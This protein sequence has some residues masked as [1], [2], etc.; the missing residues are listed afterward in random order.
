VSK[1]R[2]A[3]SL[4]AAV[5]IVLVGAGV[6]SS[7]LC[8][9]WELLPSTPESH[10]VIVA[11]RTYLPVSTE[12]GGYTLEPHSFPSYPFRVLALPPDGA[13]IEVAV[14]PERGDRWVGSFVPAT[15]GSWTL[16]ITNLRGSEARCYRDGLLRVGD[17]RQRNLWIGIVAAVAVAT[18]AGLLL[19]RRSRRRPAGSS[20][21][22]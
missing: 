17:T 11:F 16:R 12:D 22:T 13:A 21:A 6:A 10:R 7:A 15:A 9:R 14:S 20:P 18:S 3:G 2:M 4:A 8:A 5:G 19:A 1:L